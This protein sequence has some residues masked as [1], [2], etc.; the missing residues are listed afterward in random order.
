MDFRGWLRD[1][2]KKH[3]LSYSELGRRGGISHARISQVL[4]GA[5]PGPEFCIAVAKGLGAD[6]TYALRLAGYLPPEKN[7]ASSAAGTHNSEIAEAVHLMKRLSPSKQASALAMLRGL[8]G[9]SPGI[10][11]GAASHGLAYAAQDTPEA[12]T[13]QLIEHLFSEPVPTDQAVSDLPQKTRAQIIQA[14][15]ALF[16]AATLEEQEWMVRQLARAV[17]E[18]R[19]RQNDGGREDI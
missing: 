12:D 3:G 4:G 6:P 9:S 11:P 2:I 14:A 5:N 18:H 13:A 19:Q 16:N 17:E 15:D 1:E 10:S 7:H 8:A